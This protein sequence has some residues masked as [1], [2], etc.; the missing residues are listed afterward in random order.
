MKLVDLNIRW[1]RMVFIVLV[2]MLSFSPSSAQANQQLNQQADKL[3]L[4]VNQDL[5][6][7]VWTDPA[8]D[9]VVSQQINLYIEVATPRWFTGG[10]RIGSV[11]IDNVVV[12]RREKFAVNSTR[13]QDQQTWTVQLWTLT[14]YPQSAGDYIV[15][16]ITLEV[17]VADEN[18]EPGKRQLTTKP[19]SFSAAIPQPVSDKLGSIAESSWIASTGLEVNESY[20]KASTE[21]NVGDSLKRTIEIKSENVAAMM[22]PVW[23]FDSTEGLAT[24]QDPGKIEDKVNRGTYLASRTEVITYVVEEAGYY[25]LPQ[26][27]LYWWDLTSQSLQHEVLAERVIST[28][29]SSASPVIDG[30]KRQASLESLIEVDI[31]KVWVLVM[32]VLVAL[33]GFW[34]LKNRPSNKVANS[35]ALVS[36][37][38]LEQ[39]Y[40][41]QCRIGNYSDAGNLIY[42]WLRGQIDILDQQAKELKLSDNSI[43]RWLRSISAEHA[44]KMFDQLMT[45]AHGQ[46]INQ[47]NIKNSDFLDLETLPREVKKVLT[48]I[49]QESN[50][51]KSEF[52]LN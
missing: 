29:G 38:R 7:N 48:T 3:E 8:A 45:L 32:M 28:V 2:N 36:V 4:S 26:L 9:A 34:W 39:E 24:Y 37:S 15:P 49:R 33:I 35:Q 47:S 52:R 17:S 43:R 16:E 44:L 27:E 41:Q 42:Q 50:D 14:L 18:A 11:E 12:L 1:Q 22:L 13:V 21:L 10:T 5:L 19:I 46:A 31:P 30:R 25:T 51:G 20:D 6:L 23:Q 40:I